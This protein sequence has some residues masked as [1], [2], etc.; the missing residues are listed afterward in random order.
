MYTLLL[1]SPAFFP[2][3]LPSFS[4]VSFCVGPQNKIGHG[5]HRYRHLMPVPVLSARGIETGCK[6][7]VTVF[8]GLRSEI[9]DMI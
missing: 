8:L 4:Y 9:V 5:T 2:K 1:H 7:S 6:T 3:P